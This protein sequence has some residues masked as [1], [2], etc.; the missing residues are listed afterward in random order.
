MED[1]LSPDNVSS[2]K[3][4]QI[5][6]NEVSHGVH[7]RHVSVV[8]SP[9]STLSPE[10]SRAKRTVGVAAVSG[11]AGTKSLAQ[12]VEDLSTTTSEGEAAGRVGSGEAVQVTNSTTATG[13][14]RRRGTAVLKELSSS[15]SPVAVV[16]KL[17][18]LIYRSAINVM[19]NL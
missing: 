4:A 18:R 15:P 2:A 11:S 8:N 17:I 19:M 16:A 13:R 9:T 12:K 10:I 6:S 1:T 14:G 3:S 5:G 7:L